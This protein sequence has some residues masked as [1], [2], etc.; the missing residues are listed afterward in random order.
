MATR[1]LSG[2]IARKLAQKLGK[3]LKPATLIK[4]TPGTRTPGAVSGGTNPTEAS[5]RARG[6]VETVTIAPVPGST[7]RRTQIQV[8]LLGKTIAGGVEPSV[9][10]KVTIEGA[11]YR[12]T[13][14]V[15]RDPDGA[16]WTFAATKQ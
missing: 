15:G 1:L 11:T 2:T 8:S 5:H 6:M 3:H 4:V 7:V 14:I 9:G 16:M 13:E 12:L 10:D